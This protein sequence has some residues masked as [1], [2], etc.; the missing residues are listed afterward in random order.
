[1]VMGDLFKSF[2]RKVQ[3]IEATGSLQESSEGGVAGAIILFGRQ[4]RR[5]KQGNSWRCGA[6]KRDFIRLQRTQYICGKRL[7]RG[8]DYRCN[9]FR[10]VATQGSRSPCKHTVSAHPTENE[11]IL[12]CHWGLGA[13]LPLRPLPPRGLE[14][15]T[16]GWA[17]ESG[18]DHSAETMMCRGGSWHHWASSMKVWGQLLGRMVQAS[19]E[20]ESV[21][22]AMDH[23]KGFQPYHKGLKQQGL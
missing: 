15:S 4:D 6:R 21:D 20:R 1:M 10:W 5:E 8:R 23:S 13:L 16:R 14:T 9:L 12:C 17:L 22:P 11:P 19:A 3:E 18:N 7:R 2:F